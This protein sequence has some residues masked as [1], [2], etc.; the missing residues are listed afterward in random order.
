MKRYFSIAK[1][2]ALT[3]TARDTY[4]IFSGNLLSAFLGFIYTLI[5]ARALTVAGF[6]VFSAATNLI[7]IIVSLSDLGIAGT[8]VHFVAKLRAEGKETEADKYIKSTLIIRLVSTLVMSLPLVIFPS[9]FAEE[10]MA[11]DQR[12]LSYWVFLS[13]MGFVFYSFFPHVL[14]GGKK[15]VES[16]VLENSYGVIRLGLTLVFF[17]LGALNISTLFLSFGL[18][19]LGP[20]ILGILFIGTGFLLAKTDRNVYKSIFLFSSWLG[21][22]KI[23]SSVSGRLDVQMLA[24][25]AGAEETGIYSIPSRLTLFIV[26]MASSFS[27][28]LAPRLSSFANRSKEK[29]YI[30]KASL[31][32]IPIIGGILLWIAVAE[33]FIVLLFGEKYISSVPI[34]RILA[35]STIPFLITAPAVSAIVYAMKKTVYIGTFAIPQLAVIFILN[36]IFIP[37]YGAYGPAY[38]LIITHSILAIYVWSIVIKHYWLDK[39]I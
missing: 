16:V 11:T 17:Y 4:I 13:T 14:Q 36:R 1:N 27:A 18:A 15:F 12:S 20:L 26:I 25:L 19:N 23:I 28:V 2:L 34:F 22:N 10:F 5:A 7:Y 21:V 33:P 6:G 31:A 3:A 24:S 29:V 8:I 37:V 38:T 30:I 32:L 39:K 35:I 9:F